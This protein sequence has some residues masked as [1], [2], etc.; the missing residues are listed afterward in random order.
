MTI[1]SLKISPQWLDEIIDYGKRFEVRKNDRDFKYGD[2][3]DLM[4][5]DGQFYTGQMVR[6]RITYILEYEDFRDG[7]APGYCVIGFVRSG[8]I[9]EEVQIKVRKSQNDLN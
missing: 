9:V 7:I 2:Y 1:H 5:W 8:S 4:A 3:L 6:V